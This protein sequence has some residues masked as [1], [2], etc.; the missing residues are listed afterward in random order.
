MFQKKLQKNANAIFDSRK[1][2]KEKIFLKNCFFFIFY[3]LQKIRN[4]IKYNFNQLV[5]GKNYFQLP[6]KMS[7]NPNWLLRTQEPLYFQNVSVLTF[8]FTKKTR[9]KKN[10][11]GRKTFVFFK[12]KESYYF[13]FFFFFFMFLGIKRRKCILSLTCC[14]KGRDKTCSHRKRN[15][16]QI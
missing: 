6:S 1:L 8:V 10:L 16:L 5:M 14:G 4:K 12:K 11:Q 2:R 3:L 7:E 13:L 15:L 9:R